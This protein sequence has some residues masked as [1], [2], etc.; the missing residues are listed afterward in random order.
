MARN[1]VYHITAVVHL[2]R[3]RVFI[4]RCNTAEVKGGPHDGH[5]LII[6]TAKHGCG[7]F[8]ESV[9][10]SCGAV[11]SWGHGHRMYDCSPGQAGQL[12][13]AL[14]KCGDLEE[15]AWGWDWHRL[16]ILSAQRA[17]NGAE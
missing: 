17:Q 9:E 15:H 12:L 3:A 16:R 1:T 5:R 2:R 6:D 11:Y 8:Y 4:D 7:A 14:P 10:C 13:H